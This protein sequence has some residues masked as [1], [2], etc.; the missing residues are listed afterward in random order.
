MTKL[1]IDDIRTPSDD[2]IIARSSK[3]AIAWISRKGMPDFIS[4]DHDLGGSDTAMAVVHWIIETTLNGHLIIP[5]NF[6]FHV[7]SMNPVGAENI[8]K[9]MKKFLEHI[10]AIPINSAGFCDCD[11]VCKVG[12]DNTPPCHWSKL[13]D[14][15]P[16]YLSFDEAFFKENKM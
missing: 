5:G 14:I 10:R 7:H 15:N 1:Y 9:T 2:W 13:T 12:K 16:Y 4:F 11:V 8:R 3:D 6:D